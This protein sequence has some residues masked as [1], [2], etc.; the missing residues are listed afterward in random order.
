M[1]KMLTLIWGPLVHGDQMWWG[2]FVHGDQLSWG[3]NV[4]GDQMD[5][6]HLSIGTKWVWGPSELGTKC[7]TAILIIKHYCLLLIN[8][9]ADFSEKCCPFNK[10]NSSEENSRIVY[11]ECVA[12]WK[13]FQYLIG[14]PWAN[15]V[16]SFMILHSYF[17]QSAHSYKLSFYHQKS[18]LL[19][20][21]WFE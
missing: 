7:V 21:F 5:R 14:L 10:I 2:P 3:P 9:I 6:D 13:V 1:V 11:I 18:S 15:G 19:Q 8:N 12:G 17:S 16:E 20:N 4:F